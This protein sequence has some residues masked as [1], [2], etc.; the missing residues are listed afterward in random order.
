MELLQ[1]REKEVFETLKRLKE[2]KFVMIGGYAVSAYT[3]PRFS[4][5][6]DMVVVD[7]AELR[8]IQK[9]LNGRGYEK[10]APLKISPF[11]NF[12]RYEK[13]LGDNFKVSFDVFIG[14]V[15]DRQT[16]V[17]IS[18]G[19]ILENSGIRSLKGKTIFEELRLRIINVDALFIMKMISCRS[20]DIRDIFMLAQNINDKSFIKH[21]VSSR[22]SFNNRLE[23]VKEKITSKGF[24][25]G[26]Q[27]IYGIIDD[28]IFE[29]SV[30]SILS[31]NDKE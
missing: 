23:K 5:D 15:F 30:N 21:E 26:L 25:D 10:K 2:F 20:T 13:D 22:Y 24:K 19:W 3:L 18:A 1:L 9:T 6:C 28:Q 7:E 27:G 4:V 12:E 29:K 31:L 17:S 11:S 16:K 8:K 14:E